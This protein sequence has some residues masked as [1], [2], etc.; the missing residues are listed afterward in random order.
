ML[1]FAVLF[2]ETAALFVTSFYLFKYKNIRKKAERNE[3]AL[4]KLDFVILFG[5]ILLPH[6]LSAIL[7]A[8]DDYYYGISFIVL[9][10]SVITGLLYPL[11]FSIIPIAFLIVLIVRI[12]NTKK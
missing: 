3:F 11:A 2:S 10:R 6:I 9:F 4:K 8:I 5:S 1:I 7:W 12:K